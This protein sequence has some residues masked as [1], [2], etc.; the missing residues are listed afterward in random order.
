M[1]GYFDDPKCLRGMLVMAIPALILTFD[2]NKDL[3]SHLIRENCNQ[4]ELALLFQLSYMEIKENLHSFYNGANPSGWDC[5]RIHSRWKA[6]AD[7][8]RGGGEG[9]KR[10]SLQFLI[11]MES[12]SPRKGPPKSGVFL[13]VPFPILLSLKSAIS[14]VANKNSLPKGIEVSNKR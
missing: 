11:E 7:R 5:Y 2:F 1:V 8:C 10:P 14:N 9:Y 6:E 4:S 12:L 13:F 3:V